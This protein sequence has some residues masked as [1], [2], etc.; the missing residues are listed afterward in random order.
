MSGYIR[1]A[2]EGGVIGMAEVGTATVRIEADTSGLRKELG[3]LSEA[4]ESIPPVEVK[5]VPHWF[6]IGARSEQG[7]LK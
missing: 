5:G 2:D 6:N 7:S 4:W 3:S 1:K